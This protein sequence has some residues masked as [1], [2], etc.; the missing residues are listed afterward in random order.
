[1]TEPITLVDLIVAM[2]G[3]HKWCV[4]LPY[5]FSLAASFEVSCLHSLLH[6]ITQRIS[7]TYKLP[8]VDRFVN[9]VKLQD[10]S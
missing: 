4:I 3:V 5:Q 6:G 2:V 8:S 9:T 7:V 10:L 1:M